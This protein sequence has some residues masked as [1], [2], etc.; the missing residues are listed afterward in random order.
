M[1]NYDGMRNSFFKILRSAFGDFQI[2][3]FI[4]FS[5]YILPPAANAAAY[6]KQ[7]GNQKQKSA[8]GKDR[9]NQDADPQ[10]NSKNPKNPIGIPAKHLP[11]LLS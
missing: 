1:R 8:H 11:P 2:T 5:S 7:K 3:I 9:G 4:T 6:N 10:R